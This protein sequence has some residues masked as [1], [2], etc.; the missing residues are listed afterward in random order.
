MG[1]GALL[2]TLT[3]LVVFYEPK[4]NANAKTSVV[5]S[6]IASPEHIYGNRKHNILARFTQ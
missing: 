4:C 5:V 3:L 2:I 6:R 1:E